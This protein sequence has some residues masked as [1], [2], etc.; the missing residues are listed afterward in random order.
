MAETINRD[1]ITAVILAGGRGQR[2]EGQ[3]KGLISLWGQPLIAHSLKVLRSQVG[4]IVISANRNLEHYRKFGCTV[5]EDTMGENWGPLA[6]VATAMR[7]VETPYLLSVPCDCPC[8]PGDLVKRMLGSLESEKPGICII[9][10]GN[11]L[12]N[13]FALLPCS[14]VDDLDNYLN[15]NQ[16]KV[17]TW[18]RR[19]NL[20]EVDFS[21]Y[22]SAFENIN[23]PEQL[24]NLERKQDCS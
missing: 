8:L 3:D 15:S 6:G 11:R 19:H 18:L 10:D 5:F 22:A 14:L 4:E 13:A 20:T 2:M 16:R 21:D 9:H 7:H 24:R 23:T 17:E 12:Q 1:D